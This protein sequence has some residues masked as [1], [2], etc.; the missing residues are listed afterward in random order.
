MTKAVYMIVSP[1]P[2]LLDT[3]PSWPL[4]LSVTRC[5]GN[6]PLRICN[7]MQGCCS[8]REPLWRSWTRPTGVAVGRVTDD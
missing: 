2:F 4:V 1:S 8:L 6:L 7:L 3:L 5:S